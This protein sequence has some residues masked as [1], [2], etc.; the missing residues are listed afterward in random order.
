M[1]VVDF[2]NAV[3]DVRANNVY[4]PM[5][6]GNYMRFNESSA[7]Y[8]ATTTQITTNTSNRVIRDTPTKTTIL[9]MG[10]FTTSGTEF[11]MGDGRYNYP[12]YRMWKVSNISF[13]ANDTYA[14]VIDIE[15]SGNT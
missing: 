8:D 12:E 15:V 1:A 2:S 5:T 6:Q 14:F 9:Y 7:L 11:Y 10:T 3:L 4:N 13:S